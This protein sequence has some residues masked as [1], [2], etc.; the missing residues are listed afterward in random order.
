M[1]EDRDYMRQSEYDEPRWRRRFGIH[2][3]WTMVLLLANLLV[4]VL[5]E[6]NKAYNTEGFVKIFQYCALSNGG[7]SHGYIWQFITFQ[8]LHLGRWH[9]AR[10]MLAL[11]FLGRAVEVMIG[12]KRFLLL[13]I[14][15]GIIGGVFQTA[16]GLIFPNVF[17]IPVVGASAGV[18]GLL[19]ALAALE[20]DGEMLMFFVLPVKTR[21]LVW[22]AVIVAVF[23]I[24]V[25][26]EPGVA[27]AA[28]L[29]GIAMGWFFVRKILH[30]DWSR[31]TGA[32]RPVK[33]EKPRRARVIVADEPVAD[34]AGEVD[35]I[36]EKISA[37]GINSLTKRE[38]EILESARKK[39][40][41]S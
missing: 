31:L 14:T 37:H 22:V 10:K 21:H 13:Y 39:M 40:S 4:F 20:P 5:M 11:F 34:G 26:A 33:K 41:R 38:R 25:P 29:G 8:F 23:Y 36:L 17:G 18:F 15:S 7:L 3:S 2:W 32:L 35:T 9:I 24:I 30:G 6:I 19:A 27:H 1:L 12:R 28:H 16:L